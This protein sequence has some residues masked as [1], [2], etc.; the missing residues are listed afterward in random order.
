MKITS[1][2]TTVCATALTFALAA[3]LQAKDDQKSDQTQPNRTAT[4]GKS[5]TMAPAP[6]NKAS[7]L[8]GMA[9][10][11]QSGE[12]IGNIKD[13][14]VDI[15]QQKVS[16]AVFATDGRERLF[17]I[18]LN[19]IQPATDQKHLVLNI[20]KQKLEN[21][22]GFEKD[23][24]PNVTSPTFESE[25]FYHLTAV[26]ITPSQIQSKEA[27]LSATGKELAVRE[28]IGVPSDL[29]KASKLIGMNIKNQQNE[30][31]GEIKDLVVDLQS[32][33]VSYAVLGYGGALGIG[34]K[35]LAV[36]VNAFA[37]SSDFK[38]LTLNTTKDRLERAQ[39]FDRHNWP[40]VSNPTWGADRFWEDQS[41][42]FN[43]NQQQKNQDQ[44]PNPNDTNPANPDNPKK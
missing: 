27:I 19:A 13:L 2:K 43:Q 35:M 12:K 25:P 6:F 32:G 18:P 16:Y 36:P 14:V 31:V 4:Y 33:Q 21:A 38:A 1:L 15:N 28:S 30:T 26:E 34:Q 41:G 10:K 8:I 37:T 23:S 5:V 44:L 42:N 17:A 11:D 9:V 20:D 3:G 39:G 24:W 7:S 29:N 22:K 40:S